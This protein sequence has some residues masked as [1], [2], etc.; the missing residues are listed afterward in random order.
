M[1]ANPNKF[2]LMIL[3]PNATDDIELILGRNTTINSEISVTAPGVTIDYRL[4]LNGHI[5]ACCLKAARQL[6]ALTRISK[7]FDINSKKNIFCSFIRSN[8]EYCPLVWYFCGKTNTQK[9]EKISRND[10]FAYSMTHLNKR[11]KNYYTQQVFFFTL[12]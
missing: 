8:F 9:L 3:S 7:H 5:S 12:V 1:K 11:K 6:N 2:Q 4:T 10:R